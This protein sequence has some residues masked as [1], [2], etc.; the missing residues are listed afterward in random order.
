MG[1]V[2]ERDEEI[3][4]DKAVFEV[5]DLKGFCELVGWKNGDVSRETFGKN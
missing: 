3:I 4:K 5:F 1:K 2:R